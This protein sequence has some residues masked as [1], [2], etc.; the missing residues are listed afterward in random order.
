MGGTVYR[1]PMEIKKFNNDG[2]VYPD[3]SQ[4]S[5]RRGACREVGWLYKAGGP[6]G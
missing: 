1:L 2:T 6:C 5:R 4:W 3:G